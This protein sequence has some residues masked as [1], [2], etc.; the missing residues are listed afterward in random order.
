MLR[1]NSTG[2]Q[3]KLCSLASRVLKRGV[4][5]L[6]AWWLVV[7][8][9]QTKKETVSLGYI[10]G[11]ILYLLRSRKGFAPIHI[12]IR[13]SSKNACIKTFRED[14]AAAT[15]L[16]RGATFFPY[17]Y[18]GN[19]NGVVSLYAHAQQW[20]RAKTG[21]KVSH[22]SRMISRYIREYLFRCISRWGISFLPKSNREICRVLS[23]QRKLPDQHLGSDLVPSL[24]LCR[25][26]ICLLILATRQGVI[27]SSSSENVFIKLTFKHISRIHH[28]Q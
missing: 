21:R 22:W 26:P 3:E 28:W 24:S 17:K 9:S 25:G 23:Q 13:R 5:G 7:G 8:P 14:R 6:Y 15:L 16:G 27:L 20:S 18:M 12:R 1:C 11:D 19:F 10:T 4:V 2:I